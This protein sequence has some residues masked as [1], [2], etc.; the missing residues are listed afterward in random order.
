MKIALIGTGRWGKVLL[1]ELA[2]Q[3]EV[4]YQCDSES[5]LNQVFNDKEVEA[6]FIATP[7]ST[8]FDIASRALEAGKHVFLEKPGTESASNLEKL[9][10]KAKEKN[11]K[12]AI[13]YEFPHHKAA[14][15]LKE[16]I[17]GK[18]V[19]SVRFDWQK[20]GTFKDSAIPHLLSHEISI[21][22]SLGIN[23]EPV[24]HKV[25]KVVSDTDILETEFQNNIKSV[26]NRVSPVK[27]KTLTILTDD[28][29]YI[30]SNNELFEIDGD[31]LK[32]IDLSE[33][34][35]VAEEIKDFLDAIQENRE[36]FCNGNFALGVYGVIERI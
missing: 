36:P 11:L 10:N 17:Q 16:L 29:S 6:V 34:T 28:G 31:T 2:K 19:R 22:H 8:H 35:P 27:Q 23:M 21:A 30:W 7:T 13:G 4:K 1:H 15:K 24:S 32:T 5:D 26:I 9:V 12:F 20:W 33:A 18:Q 14:K 25:T 3:A